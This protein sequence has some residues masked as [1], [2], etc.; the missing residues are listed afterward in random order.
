MKVS[1][2]VSYWQ[3]KSPPGGSLLRHTE[4]STGKSTDKST[5]QVL[6]TSQK[7]AGIQ[8]TE[9]CTEESTEKSTAKSTAKVYNKSTKILLKPPIKSNYEV[10]RMVTE[11]DIQRRLPH[12]AASTSQCHLPMTTGCKIYSIE[13]AEALHRAQTALARLILV[14]ITSIEKLTC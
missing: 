9:T 10:D 1:K 5:S 8:S 12:H 6:P 14:S 11:A 3:T 7:P 2:N 4:K 13:H